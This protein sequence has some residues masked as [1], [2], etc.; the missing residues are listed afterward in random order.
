MQ[1]WALSCITFKTENT[2]VDIN[3]MFFSSQQKQTVHKFKNLWTALTLTLPIVLSMLSMSHWIKDESNTVALQCFF[4]DCHY[5]NEQRMPPTQ[6]S[7]S[8]EQ[9]E[10]RKWTKF[11]AKCSQW[12]QLTDAAIRFY[13]VHFKCIRNKSALQ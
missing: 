10:M 12:L 5:N 9:D 1:V 13:T 11:E 2:L 8:N 6:F 3:H 7:S 4:H